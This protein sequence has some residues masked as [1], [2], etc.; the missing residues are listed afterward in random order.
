MPQKGPFRASAEDEARSIRRNRPV[1]RRWRNRTRQAFVRPVRFPLNTRFPPSARPATSF[2]FSTWPL[3]KSR[4]TARHPLH[5]AL[6]PKRNA[7]FAYAF[8]Q[9]TKGVMRGEREFTPLCARFTRDRARRRRNDEPTEG[10]AK[11]ITRKRPGRKG[12]L[13]FGRARALYH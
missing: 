6:Y 4:S 9:V 1:H 5:T 11:R 7:S 13:E 8:F 10:G 2:G 3:P 12:R